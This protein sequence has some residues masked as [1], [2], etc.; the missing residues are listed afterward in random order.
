MHKSFRSSGRG[1]MSNSL[2]IE[3]VGFIKE[4]IF[5]LGLNNIYI[6]KGKAE[7]EKQVWIYVNR[8]RGMT[9]ITFTWET[10]KIIN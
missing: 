7:P 1:C 5:Y 9:E 4:E 2:L 8:M 3:F 10:Y 6:Y